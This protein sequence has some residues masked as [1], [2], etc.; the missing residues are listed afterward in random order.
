MKF[1]AFLC[2]PSGKKKEISVN[3]DHKNNVL[4]AEFYPNEIGNHWIYFLNEANLD[5]P[6]N[7]ETSF[8]LIVEDCENVDLT[9]F[10][11]ELESI[12]VFGKGLV[13]GKTGGSLI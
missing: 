6:I 9:K 4:W 7:Y 8:Q 2:T 1:L 3:Y 10:L 13:K 12:K 11:G 5:L